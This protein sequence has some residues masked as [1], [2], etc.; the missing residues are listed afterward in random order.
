[1]KGPMGLADQS[2]ATD[3]ET[4]PEASGRRGFWLQALALIRSLLACRRDLE[5]HPP[6]GFRCPP[7]R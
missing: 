3:V 7:E 5:R 1:M 2:A 6:V 4:E